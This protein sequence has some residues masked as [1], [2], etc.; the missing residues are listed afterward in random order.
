MY[1]YIKNLGETI[2]P[3]TNKTYWVSEGKD[4]LPQVTENNMMSL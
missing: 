4:L 2:A 1:I 3:A